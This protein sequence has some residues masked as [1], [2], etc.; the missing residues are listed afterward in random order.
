[1]W[2]SSSRVVTLLKWRMNVSSPKGREEAHEG[3]ELA[4]AVL[5]AKVKKGDDHAH[6][7]SERGGDGKDPLERLKYALMKAPVDS[8]H[9]LRPRAWLP[10]GSGTPASFSRLPAGQGAR[11]FSLAGLVSCR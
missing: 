5:V 6:G 11:A 2:V 8:G 9:A 1:M 7:D 3:V 10:D 4:E